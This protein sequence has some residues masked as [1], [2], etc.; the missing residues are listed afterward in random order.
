MNW[1]LFVLLAILGYVSFQPSP[2][3]TR[4]NI[5]LLVIFVVLMVLWALSGMGVFEGTFLRH[6]PC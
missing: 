2:I 4:T 5:V 3:T 6:K 1:F